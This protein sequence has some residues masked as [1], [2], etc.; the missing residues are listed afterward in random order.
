M[1][2]ALVVQVAGRGVMEEKAG[3]LHVTCP[4]HVPLQQLGALQ[5]DQRFACM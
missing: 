3:G 2:E 5:A 1:K 4:V